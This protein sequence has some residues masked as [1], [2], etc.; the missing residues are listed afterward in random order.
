VDHAER[1]RVEG[2]G[3][4]EDGLMQASPWYVWGCFSGRKLPFGDSALALYQVGVHWSLGDAGTAI[5]AGRAVNLADLRTPERRA[6]FHTDI[7]RAWWR[8]GKPEQTAV[9]LLAAQ[10]ESRAGVSDRPAIRAIVMELA[11]RHERLR[12][13]RQLAAQVGQPIQRPTW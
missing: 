12:A 5:R 3:H 9:A 13:V 8:W 6:R 11:Q 2:F 4:L 10:V 7:A 1:R